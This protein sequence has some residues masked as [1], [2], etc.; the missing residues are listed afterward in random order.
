MTLFFSIIK[1]KSPQQIEAL[2]IGSYQN[3]MYFSEFILPVESE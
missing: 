2:I 3:N 1:G